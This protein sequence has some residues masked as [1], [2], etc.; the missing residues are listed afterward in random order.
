M[1]DN[2]DA[3]YTI[4]LRS[5]TEVNMANLLITVMMVLLTTVPSYS[6]EPHTNESSIMRADLKEIEPNNTFDTANNIGLLIDRDMIQGS[7]DSIEDIDHYSFQVSEGEKFAITLTNIDQGNN[8]NIFLYDE[9]F[10][11]LNSSQRP[12]N[13]NEIVR[14]DSGKIAT[15]YL[16]VLPITKT[17]SFPD[18]Y[19]LNFRTRIRKG[20]HTASFSP[21][22]IS[23]SGSS[24]FSEI[25]SVDLR[26]DATIPSGACVTR[27]QVFGSQ[28][29]SL[30]NTSFQLKNTDSDWFNSISVN[31]NAP[32]SSI[33][34]N[35]GLLVKSIWQT[36]YTS[37]DKNKSSFQD[38]KISFTFFYDQT[39]DW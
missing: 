31:G 37:K 12:D 23:S 30:G 16:R 25:T 34:S 11:L 17:T 8:F 24:S 13:T 38:L 5:T 10:Q 3:I 35:S 27:L 14:H 6:I 18:Y 1:I 39:A 26:S 2:F 21:A 20:N 9:N 28:H 36:R 29:P 19:F 7:V 32:F 15:Y 22:S 33:N 4:R